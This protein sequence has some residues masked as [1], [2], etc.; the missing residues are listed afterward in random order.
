MESCVHVDPTIIHQS[1]TL[2]QV[3][4]YFGHSCSLSGIHDKQ[5]LPHRGIFAF[6]WIIEKFKPRY[7]FHGHVHV[8]RPDEPVDTMWGQTR[9]I[10]AYGYKEIE[11]S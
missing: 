2:W 7:H 1:D 3:F 5:D 11:L 8:Y 10:N 6:R 9:V 4:R